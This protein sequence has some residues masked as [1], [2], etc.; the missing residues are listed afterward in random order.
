[1]CVL[2]VA[3]FGVSS[4]VVCLA[5]YFQTPLDEVDAAAR[6]L[7]PVLSGVGEPTKPRLFGVFFKDYA[8][9]EW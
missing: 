8:E 3:V 9:T 5:S 4:Y 1:M 2:G 6:V 7:D